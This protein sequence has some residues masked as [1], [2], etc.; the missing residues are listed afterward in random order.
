MIFPSHAWL[1]RLVAEVN[2]NPDTP[3]ALEGLAP[4]V[5]AVIEAHPPELPSHFAVYGEH[6]GGRIVSFRV[7][8]DADDLLE[9]EPDFVLR[10]PYPVWTAL[11]QGED[12]VKAA[13]SG[14]VRVQ[15][16]L[17]ALVRRAHHRHILD[18]ALRQIPTELAGEGG[19]R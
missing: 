7:L 6:R 16:D 17:Q 5:G 2:A 13:L 4:T 15:G 12:P 1:A 10:A 3:R 9:L 8:A 14:R 19:S 11:L 18:A